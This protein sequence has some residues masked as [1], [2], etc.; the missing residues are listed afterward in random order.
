MIRSFYRPFLVFN[1]CLFLLSASAQV[2][3]YQGPSLNKLIHSGGLAFIDFNK[4]GRLDAYEDYRKPIRQRAVDL[5]A[6]MTIEEKIAQLISPWF[7]KASLFTDNTF[8]SLKARA[9]FPNGIGEILQI[10]HGAHVLSAPATPTPEKISVAANDIQHFFINNTRGDTCN[11]F[12]R[13]ASW[14]ND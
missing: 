11:V 7:G 13:S 9:A 14:A 2:G 6:K 5:L 8:D 1:F 12:R 3:S 10:S 4:N